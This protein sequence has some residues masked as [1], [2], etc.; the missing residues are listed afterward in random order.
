MLVPHFQ[1]LLDQPHLQFFPLSTA[2]AGWL[3]YASGPARLA[4]GTR[5]VFSAMLVLAGIALSI[6][7]LYLYSFGG[8]H[9]AWVLTLTGWALG[10]YS[11]VS[12]TRVLAISMLMFVSIPLPSGQGLNLI[13]SLQAGTSMNCSS[14]FDLIGL[15]H[16]LEGNVIEI[17][18]KRLFVEEACSGIDSLYALAAVGIGIVLVNKHTFIPALFTLAMV[19]VWAITCNALRIVAITVGIEYFSIDL[20][21]GLSHTILGLVLFAIA[22]LG[23]IDTEHLITRVVKAREL[24]PR[25]GRFS[26]LVD[27]L[28]KWPGEHSTSTPSE[29]DFFVPSA[30]PR[31]AVFVLGFSCCICCVIGFLS[32]VA[33]Y[34]DPQ[35]NYVT[36]SLTEDEAKLLPSGL[37][38]P[39]RIG[40]LSR[41]RFNDEQRDS[42]SVFGKYSHTWILSGEEGQSIASLDFPFIGWHSL[43]ICYVSTGWTVIGSNQTVLKSADGKPW[44][45]SEFEIQNKSGEFGYVLYAHFDSAG[46]PVQVPT[47]TGWIQERNLL[48]RLGLFS[49]NIESGS[50]SNRYQVQ[51]FSQSNKQLPI[52]RKEVLRSDFL[53]LFETLRVKSIPA[54]NKINQR[55]L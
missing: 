33:L 2:F 3:L 22:S 40:S 14:F 46:I 52:E 44:S 30:L 23:L 24:L 48:A 26:R 34:S 10:A 50:V 38:M 19:P 36:S 16:L 49:S 27:W 5:L 15:K 6:G 47:A 18:S 31:F 54:L 29:Q 39:V 1:R 12:Y 17:S 11:L 21:E 37:D 4:H 8:V 20:S 13:Q 43:S 53:E 7:G 45:L 41:V 25:T 42:L 51:L 32:F 35:L 55:S 9:F 28:L